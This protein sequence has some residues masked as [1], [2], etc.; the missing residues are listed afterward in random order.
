MTNLTDKTVKNKFTALWSEHS[1]EKRL[2]N[3]AQLFTQKTYEEEYKGLYYLCAILVFLTGALSAVF[4]WHYSFDLGSE[5]LGS[6]HWVLV[7]ALVALFLFV[8]EYAKRRVFSSFFQAYF[9]AFKVPVGTAFLGFLV[10]AVS[11][12]LSVLGADSFVASETAVNVENLDAKAAKAVDSLEAMYA[13][14]QA[15]LR[16]NRTEIIARNTYKGKTWLPK[17]E[18]KLVQSI[19]AKILAIDEKLEAGLSSLEKQKA[20][21]AVGVQD[22]GQEQ[23]RRML[24][25]SSANELLFL[26][27]LYFLWYYRYR[28]L[29][30]LGKA[31]TQPAW[32]ASALQMPAAVSGQ[33]QRTQAGNSASVTLPQPLH[34]ELLADVLAG[35][36]NSPELMKKHGVN[37]T[38]ASKY[39]KYG[40]QE[41]QKRKAANSK[42]QQP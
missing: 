19:E 14:K 1:R 17:A 21:E 2:Q 12:A 30:E 8:V 18:R 23:W 37:V 31:P 40:K 13:R 26:A 9:E 29:V 7:A 22:K 41:E 35:N 39:V 11:V 6:L 34:V 38:L 10:I 42:T 28:V 16:Q 32:L 33:K 4:A 5:F 36:Y 24:G 20:S 25:L 3:Y 15:E 27:A